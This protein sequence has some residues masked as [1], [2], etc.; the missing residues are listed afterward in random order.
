MNK[1]TAVMFVLT[2][3]LCTWWVGSTRPV[4]IW[5]FS[6]FSNT[7]A[8]SPNGQLLAT[9]SGKTGRKIGMSSLRGSSQMKLLNLSNGSEVRTWDVFIA[10]SLAF[11]PDSS[12]IAVGNQIGEIF[13]WRVDDGE[14]VSS[15]QVPQPTGSYKSIASL[16]FSRNSQTLISGTSFGRIDGWNIASG[17]HIY[18]IAHKN[19]QIISFS[20]DGE[21]FAASG[22]PIALYQVS[23][24]S[25][26]RQLSVDGIPQFSPDG[27]LLGITNSNSYQEKYEDTVFF[28]RLEDDTI[29]G[30]LPIILGKLA[31]FS[32]S[33]NGRYLATLSR[34]GGVG[35]SLFVGDPR[36]PQR[37][38]Y[39]LW[40][41][42]NFFGRELL[43]PVEYSSQLRTVDTFKIPLGP[44]VFSP[45]ENFLAS[46]LSSGAKI[47]IW[48]IRPFYYHWLLKLL[49]IS[50]L[51]L[52][53]FFL[54][55][56]WRF[57]R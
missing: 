51:C 31:T 19:T 1:I 56:Y 18:Q 21:S 25:L 32:F 7:I 57:N 50:S 23:D 26:I 30:Q 28:Y 16:A 14:L 53:V 11:S 44:F 5:E 12:L 29:V 33:P 37:I 13:A 48:R 40:Q 24:G 36:P 49:Q 8:I 27:K 34:T 6:G 43:V 39:T 15:F 47:S 9:T 45:D 17:Q 2:I 10:T 46:R 35:G 54:V 20:P 55:R 41:S 22:K 42:V 38:H 3:F 52:L 4:K